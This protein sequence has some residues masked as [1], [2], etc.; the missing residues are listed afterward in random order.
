MENEKITVL[1]R[2][3]LNDILQVESIIPDLKSESKIDAIRQILEKMQG[4]FDKNKALEDILIREEDYSTGLEDG[5]AFPH[6]RTTSVRQL[7]LGFACCK[8]GIEFDSRD[9]KPS[10][11]IPLLLTPVSSGKTHIIILAEMIRKLEN[12]HIRKNL[13]KAEDQKSIY[14]ILIS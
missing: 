14:D 6:A 13:L 11:F 4:S 5:I 1:L 2:M 12:E 10:H 9:G 3:N 8:Q 7:Q